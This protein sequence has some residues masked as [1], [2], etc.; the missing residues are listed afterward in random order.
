MWVPTNQKGFGS[1]QLVDGA[2]V[3]TLDA[4]FIQTVN[5]SEEY[6]VFLTPYG[7]CK[8]LY[9]INRSANS[10]EVHELGG[11]KATL[12]FEYRITALRRNYEIVRFADYTESEKLHRLL[13]ER[14]KPVAAGSHRPAPFPL[15]QRQR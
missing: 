5:T 2:A 10:F 12:N 14:T 11:G 1:A 4:D 15:S 3:V 8:G 6:Q 13:R 7:D 9:L